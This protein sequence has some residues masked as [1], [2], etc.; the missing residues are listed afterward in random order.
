M[1]N[2]RLP[3]LTRQARHF[4][5][6]LAA[7]LNGTVTDGLRLSV[8]TDPKGRAVVGKGVGRLNLEGDVVPLTVSRARPRL[9]LY[10]IQTLDLDGEGRHLTTNK[11]SFALQTASA[12]E[13]VVTYD[14]AR[15]PPN[16]YPEAHLH[17]HGRAV[18][19]QDML[20]QCGRRK[21]KPD[22]LH[23]PVGGRRFRP[24]LEDLIEFCI[25]ERLVTPRDGW[26]AALNKSRN[27]FLDAQFRAAVR[28]FPESAA[29]ELRGQGW[30]VA[31]PDGP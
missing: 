12:D 23:F 25:L 8:S 5:G 27:R 16:A 26:S 15:D 6:E 14:Y 22:D 4:A 21:D 17:I 29:Q 19:V 10:V 20:D 18:A 9:F 24:C 3:D 30:Q 31:A 7:T 11:S 1:S 28:R 2:R 13:P